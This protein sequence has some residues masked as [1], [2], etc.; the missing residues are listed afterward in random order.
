M[1]KDVLVSISGMQI[2]IVEE[3]RE[4]NEAIEV[5]SP[6]TYFFKDGIHYIFY[7]EVQEGMR[8]VT[9]NKIMLKDDGIELVKKGLINSLM[10]F[11]IGKT[12]EFIYNTQ[13]GEIEMGIMTH[14][15]QI[16]EEE[17]K[18]FAHVRYNLS[19]NKEVHAECEIKISIKDKAQGI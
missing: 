14:Q 10:R 15:I 11:E 6:A 2:E 18:I 17:N 19:V 1:T 8:G 4:E 13:F 16:E 7:E 3:T 5:I 9:K 12:N